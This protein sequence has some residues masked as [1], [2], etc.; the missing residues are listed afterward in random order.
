MAIIAIVRVSRIHGVAGIDIVW[1]I[2]WQTMEGCVAVL[3]ASITAFRSI[4]VS[5]G[6]RKARE[7]KWT[8]S[9]SWV[10]RAKQR[11]KTRESKESDVRE[12]QHHYI[13]RALLTGMRTFIR[14]HGRTAEGTIS[15][16]SDTRFL[17]G[18]TEA[19][20]S[21]ESRPDDQQVQVSHESRVKSSLNPW[22]YPIR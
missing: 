10:Q 20:L 19:Q 9:Y 4:F 22:H 21:V 3:M 6:R 12:D 13:P 8:P 16:S 18:D 14:E 7:N 2:Y 15:T 1:E 17:D 11:Q 5:N